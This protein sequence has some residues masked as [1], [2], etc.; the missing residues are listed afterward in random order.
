M[1][2]GRTIQ[3]QFCKGI[4]KNRSSKFYLFGFLIIQ[5]LDRY[6]TNYKEKATLLFQSAKSQY[7]IFK[8]LAFFCNIN[9][10]FNMNKTNEMNRV[11]GEQI[12]IM[13]LKNN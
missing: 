10:H 8:I 11:F 13:T 2:Q 5:P 7:F 1:M 12:L 6:K 3:L 9:S 4:T